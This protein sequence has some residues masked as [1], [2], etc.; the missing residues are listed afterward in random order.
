MLGLRLK[1]ERR[2]LLIVAVFFL[3][4]PI[5]MLINAI[6]PL[7]IFIFDVFRGFLGITTPYDPRFYAVSEI[8]WHL[9]YILTSLFFA[10]LAWAF[11]KPST[12][13]DVKLP[14]AGDIHIP[15]LHYL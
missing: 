8:S 4:L 7:T 11:T 5:S 9:S 6:F 2:L 13:A 14:K 3:T 15:H 10:F 1:T 12:L